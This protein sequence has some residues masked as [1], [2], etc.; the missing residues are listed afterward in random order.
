MIVIKII[1]FCINNTY[2]YLGG[3]LF[4]NRDRY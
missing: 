2:N 4:E 3:D 1:K